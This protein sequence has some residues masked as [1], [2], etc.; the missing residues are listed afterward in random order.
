MTYYRSYY[1][2][3]GVAVTVLGLVT[4]LI[5][6]ILHISSGSL[7]DWLSGVGIFWWLLTLVVIPWNIYFEAKEVLA[8]AQI[9]QEKNIQFDP[10]YLNYV[11]KICRWSL[12]IAIS[13]HLISAIT[14]YGLAFFEITSLGYLS[15][16][17]TLL[18]TL[19]RPALRAY[20]YLATRL[21]MIR[22]SIKYPREDVL[23]LQNRL[24]MLI[25]KVKRLEDTLDVSNPHSWAISQ[26]IKQQ[27]IQQN[28]NN[29]KQNFEQF[30]QY[31]QQ[32]HYQISQ[33]AKGAIA[34]LTEDSQFLSQV[35]EIIRFF[36]TA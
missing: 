1:L 17:A 21:A 26:Q 15:A 3:F 29:L 36:K 20:Q 28:I 5:L 2:G 6:Q 16:I 14:L 13:L 9:S 35:R 32:E 31:N 8:E 22:Q 23:T 33:E 4:F 18:L 7:V 19:F 34:Q 10:A 30:K 25:D 11:Q 27:E 12:I 24:E